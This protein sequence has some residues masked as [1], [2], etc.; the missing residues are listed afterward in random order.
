M[1]F[2]NKYKTTAI[3]VSAILSYVGILYFSP[4]YANKISFNLWLEALRT[5]AI[6]KGIKPEIF[7]DLM[8]DVTPVEKIIA[9]DKKQPERTIT[10]EEYKE[11]VVTASRIR[12]GRRLQSEYADTLKK[13]E[14]KYGVQKRFILALWAIETDFGRNVGGFYVPEA[15]ATLAYDGRRG[16]FFRNELLDALQIVNDGHI[17]KDN[18]KGSWAGAMGQ[19]QF[20]PSS[21]I[22]F[23]VDY[24]GDKKKDIWKSRYDVFASIANYLDS[25]G[26]DSEGIWGR[27]VKL[28]PDFDMSLN[29]NKISKTLSEWQELG[30]R[31]ADGRDL[32]VNKISASLIAPNNKKDDAFLVYDNYKTIMDWNKSNYFA[33]SVGILSDA[34]GK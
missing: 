22:K 4:A 15:L 1:L 20:M 33:L 34:I 18:M 9:L 21:F 8:S 32:P 30:V 29:D 25:V 7:D 19:S 26:W 28:A 27:K 3:T 14:E 16:Q 31:R 24:D 13:I 5:E 12:K 23:A 6:E 17:D 2:I 11:R 10:F